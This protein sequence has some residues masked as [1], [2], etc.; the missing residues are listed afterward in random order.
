M[1]ILNQP[2]PLFTLPTVATGRTFDLAAYRGRP[3]I[4]MFVDQNTARA[5]RDVVIT[6]RQRIPSHELLP[7]AIVVDLTVIP[8]LLR[9]VAEGFMERAYQEEAAGVPP[10]FD[11][12]DHLMLLPD[13]NGE[14]AAL[15]G[16]GDVSRQIAVVA[17]NPDGFIHGSYQGPNAANETLG[18]L[19]SMG[20]ID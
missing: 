7:I 6:L 8:K 14:V 4:L 13:W 16:V 3:V 2:A 1:T 18:F 20:V 5:T 17:V 9:G 12:A 19:R 11:P 10:G 15:Y